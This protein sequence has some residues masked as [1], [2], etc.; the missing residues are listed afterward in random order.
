MDSKPLQPSDRERLSA[1]RLNRWRS[2]F[3]HYKPGRLSIEVSGFPEIV[4][5]ALSLAEHLS[6]HPG[7]VFRG[8][9]EYTQRTEAALEQAR[10]LLE[11][12]S[13]TYDS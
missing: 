1:E 10:E 2:D 9:D 11:E 13:R 7:H 5:E 6:L 8:Q 4:G 12:I 3:V